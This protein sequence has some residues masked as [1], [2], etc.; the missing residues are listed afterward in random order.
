[1][2]RTASADFQ[3]F[4][5]SRGGV[6]TDFDS[7][8][9]LLMQPNL[10]TA[11]GRA[12]SF[13]GWRSSRGEE[14]RHCECHYL[15]SAS[16]DAHAAREA[17]TFCLAVNDALPH[18][19]LDIFSLTFS[20]PS[21]FEGV[22]NVSLE[23]AS[24]AKART[25]PAGYGLFKR[26]A[27]E[28]LDVE[29]ELSYPR[30]PIRRQGALYFTGLA[31]DAIW[32]HELA[33]VFLGHVDFAD[34]HL[35]IRTLHEVPAEASDLRTMPLETEADRFGTITIVHAGMISTPYVPAAL[36][37]LPATLRVQAAL[38]V[39][40][41]LTWFWAFQQRID[42]TFDGIDPYDGGSHPPPLAR[43]H[44]AFDAGREMLAKLG[45]PAPMISATVFEAM[46]QLENLAHAKDWFSI[47][48]PANAFSESA[49]GFARDLKTMLADSYRAIEPD[50]A[51]YRYAAQPRAVT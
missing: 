21:F 9:G 31:L 7:F 20:V 30:C 33:H 22:G 25:K 36:R 51:P 37:N 16:A 32:S 4:A 29:G 18:Q 40:A 6:F 43:L 19:L 17:D 23:D 42:R 27:S 41:V 3:A 48:A 45:W 46:S 2:A 10:V 15:D 39:A 8:S 38:V 49:L 5:R 14:L 1:M 47:L 13:V 35:G 50:L 11:R 34:R 28:S 24:R 26:D 44:L 12:A